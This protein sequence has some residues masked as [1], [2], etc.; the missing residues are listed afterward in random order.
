VALKEALKLIVLVIH[1]RSGC[2]SNVSALFLNA[3]LQCMSAFTAQ[4]KRQTSGEGGYV[5]RQELGM[6]FLL[7][8]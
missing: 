4:D 2:T 1:A 8:H 7:R 6:L 3:Y 5:N